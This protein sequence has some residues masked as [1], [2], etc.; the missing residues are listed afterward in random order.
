MASSSYKMAAIRKGRAV[1][2]TTLPA[3]LARLFLAALFVG[4]VTG[5]R[6]TV[7]ATAPDT[8]S[9]EVVT[10]Y[11]EALAVQ[12]WD[13]AYQQLHAD[14]QKRFSRLAFERHVRDYG[15]RLGFPLGKVFIRSCDEQ[16]EKAIAQVIL[17][18][19]N[20]SAKARFHEGVIL[21]QSEGGW[22]VMLPS[23]FAKQ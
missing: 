20:G 19:A 11:F 7:P 5:C 17:S 3:M 10:K 21:Q 23:N 14:T 8:G 1:S 12:D 22:K 13:T 2:G 16:G 15:K 4:T 9:R 18:D 6:N